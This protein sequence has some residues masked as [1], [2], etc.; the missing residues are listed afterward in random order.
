[1]SLQDLLGAI[2]CIHS[3]T[4]TPGERTNAYNTCETF[5]TTCDNLPGAGLE[6]AKH[7]NTT[8]VRHFGYQLLDHFVKFK[9]TQIGDLEKQEFKTILI[10]NLME[11]GTLSIVEES[12]LIR[13]ILSS[14]VTELLKRDWPQQWLDFLSIVKRNMDGNTTAGEALL[15]ALARLIEDIELDSKLT[16]ARRSDLLRSVGLCKD[17]LV[18]MVTCKLQEVL[19]QAGSTKPSALHIT[20]LSALSL[21]S[22]ASSMTWFHVSSLYDKK[23]HLCT[24]LFLLLRD[25]TLR[26]GA[27]DVLYNLSAR[28]TTPADNSEFANFMLQDDALKMVFDIAGEVCSDTL[29]DEAVLFLKT[30]CRTYTQLG[31]NHISG[32][33]RNAMTIPKEAFQKYLQ[34]MLIFYQH[35]LISVRSIVV[36]LWVHFLNFEQLK[37]NEDLLMVIPHVVQ[38]TQKYFCKPLES[39]ITDDVLDYCELIKIFNILLSKMITLSGYAGKLCPNET[40]RIVFDWQSAIL[41]SQIPTENLC[42]DDTKPFN[43]WK[44]FSIFTEK[45]IAASMKSHTPV[46]I[47]LIQQSLSSLLKY[48]S[49]D[50]LISYWHIS[51]INAYVPTFKES[52][53]LTIPML[54]KLFFL[55]GNK[56]DRKYAGVTENKMS[57][58]VSD[59]HRHTSSCLLRFVT[60]YPTAITWEVFQEMQ[61]LYNT[62]LNTIDNR[63]WV[64]WLI[65][66]VNVPGLPLSAFSNIQPIFRQ[67]TKDLV[68]V[69]F[70]EYVNRNVVLH[71]NLSSPH[72]P[73]PR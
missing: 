13:N 70:R 55:L 49:S 63:R 56:F 73:L 64:M 40:L 57:A 61:S 18:D 42:K 53:A 35:H 24:L 36:D 33:F 25:K 19:E 38:A 51:T 45:I 21:L 52:D 14:L 6:L 43:V 72:S 41:S 17:Q 29:S 68:G 23:S 4:S 60:N 31:E 44:F 7:T 2:Q 27:A 50:P 15:T 71:L 62:L 46:K 10:K 20:C 67:L 16:P 48:D 37:K 65:C 34:L 1:M 32:V 8:V 22:A 69:E 12:G 59:L 47:D 66:T 3:P 30:L 11:D 39:E 5:K 54:E 58:M 28:K 9:W 26:Q